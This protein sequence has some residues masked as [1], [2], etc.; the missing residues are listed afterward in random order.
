VRFASDKPVMALLPGDFATRPAA[1]SL[2]EH[3][4]RTL[5]LAGPV[6]VA[7]CGLLIMVTVDTIMTGRAGANELAYLA[8]AFA[9]HITMLVIGI[10]VLSGTV[11]LVS[12]A[13]GA[14]RRGSCGRILWIALADAFVLGLLW[15]AVLFQGEDI[16]VLLGQEADLSRGGSE[17]MAMFAWG[18]PAIYLFTA[19]SMFLEGVGRVIPG[20]VVML[21]ANVI[22]AALNW[23]FIY[24]GM[25]L[26][27]DGASGAVL[28]TSLTRWFMFA[29]IF[30]YICLMA[31][32]AELGIFR[33]VEGIWALQKRF[34]R[35]GVP[36]ALSYAFE[37]T[38]FLSITIMAGHMGKAPVAAYQAAMN[39]NAFCFMV[40]IGMSTATSVRVGNAIGRR[41]RKGMAM[42]GWVGTGLIGAAMVPLAI[43]VALFPE[44][45]ACIYTTDATLIAIIIPALF[46]A[47]FLI[48]GDGLQGVLLGALRGAADV[49]PTTCLGFLAFWVIMVPMAWLLG[50][51]LGGGVPGLLWAEV[52]GIMTAAV[53][54]AWRF[55]VISQRKIAVF[56]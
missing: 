35:L 8:I 21:V 2:C 26:E 29:A 18:M 45:L 49:W 38:A 33:R 3:I 53:L 46:V 27:P 31:D 50:R 19:A 36:M 47:V 11:I 14:G 25:G 54:F 16:L 48:P 23:I 28:A 37:T 40:A 1:S 32:K 5:R 9:P 15:A 34:L 30:G 51:E 39:V 13:D 4:I 6:I 7:R 56:S 41:D 17:V 20:M 22:N 42:A 43:I 10:G 44:T 55:R 24:G 12:Q 52:I